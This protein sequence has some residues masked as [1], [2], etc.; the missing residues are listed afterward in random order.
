[1]ELNKEIHEIILD[2]MDLAQQEKWSKAD[3]YTRAVYDTF[4]VQNIVLNNVAL[5][6]V[7]LSLPSDEEIF[8]EKDSC[9]TS[10]DYYD[11]S[12]IMLRRGFTKGAKW[13]RSKIEGNEA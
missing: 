7:R 8:K 4:R 2:A 5:A 9:N 1:M 12:N 11:N 13:M 3:K 6:D 10:I